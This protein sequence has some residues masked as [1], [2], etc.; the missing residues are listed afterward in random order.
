VDGLY[1][2]LPTR[3]AAVQLHGRVEKLAKR[4]WSEQDRPTVVLAVPGYVDEN[5]EGAL[6]PAGDAVD[7][8]EEDSRQTASWAGEHPKRYFASTISVGSIDQALLGAIR[9]KH[10]HMRAAMLM[11]H[12]LVVDEVHASDTFMRR[13]LMNLLRDHFAAGGYA[14]LLSA[15]LG[16]EGRAAL[17][18]EAFGARSRDMN[19]VDLEE[20]IKVPYPLITAAGGSAARDEHVASTGFQKEVAMEAATLLDDANGIAGLALD[21]AGRGAKVLVLRNT[22][23]G[24]VEVQ[25]AAEAQG[26]TQ[27][28]LLFSVEGLPALHHGR[29]AREDRKLLDFAVE[30]AVGKTRPEGGLVLIGTQTLKQSLD[31]DA[32]FL[33]TDLCPADVLLQ[34]IGRLHRHQKDGCGRPRYRTS[35]FEV[36]RCVVLTPKGGL[37]QFVGERR[38]DGKPRHGLGFTVLQNGAR[39]GVYRDLAVL[40]ATRQLVLNKMVG[41]FQR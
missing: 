26:G 12:L 32:D 8:A 14:L 36:P 22:V 7:A 23:A 35:D 10:V 27:N 1:F 16:A 25:K 38:P 15:T 5:G 19:P 9:V 2:A 20:A 17:I 33:I 28:P 40:E 39:V 13:I 24:A 21:A 4:L 11:R 18:H 6:P 34:R 37:A 31:I 41:S 30:K 3:T 29:F